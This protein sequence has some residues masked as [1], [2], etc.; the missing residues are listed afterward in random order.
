MSQS[1]WKFKLEITD[2]QIVPMPLKA[3]ILSVGV[4]RGSLCLWARVN[5][6]AEVADREIEIIGTGHQIRPDGRRYIG[7]AIMEPFVWHVFERPAE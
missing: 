2:R 6:E 3:L 1:I 7:T 5:T 4:Q